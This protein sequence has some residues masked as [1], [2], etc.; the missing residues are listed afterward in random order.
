MRTRLLDSKGINPPL[1]QGRND[2]E[3]VLSASGKS[4][5]LVSSERLAR[6]LIGAVTERCLREAP[7][8]EIRAAYTRT[9]PPDAPNATATEFHRA[10]MT[11]HRRLDESRATQPGPE[12]RFLTLPIV[13]RC[14]TSP[15]PAATFDDTDVEPGP[16]SRIA[17]AKR[18]SVKDARARLKTMLGG[19][20]TAGRYELPESSGVLES[21]LGDN[22]VGVIHADGNGL[23]Q[24]FL[25]FDRIL[26]RMPASG[27]IASA[28]SYVDTLRRFSLALDACTVSAFRQALVDCDRALGLDR[29]PRSGD[30]P[31]SGAAYSPP[32]PIVPLILGGDDLTVL[33]DG[34]IALL[35]ASSFL[36]AFERETAGDSHLGGIVRQVAEAARPVRLVRSMPGLSSCAGIAVVKRHHPFH[37]AYDMAEDLLKSAK[38]V[39]RI[40][41]KDQAAVPCSALDFHINYA[42]SAD[43]IGAARAT[44]IVDGGDTRLTARPYVVTGRQWLE[45]ADPPGRAWAER[46]DW[47]DLLVRHSDL[48]R[49][50]KNSHLDSASGDGGDTIDQDTS[51]MM[52]RR[53]LHAAREALFL[54]HDRADGCLA[55]LPKNYREL[56]VKTASGRAGSLF[57]DDPD[58]AE[59]PRRATGLI[60]VMDLDEQKFEP[61][62]SPS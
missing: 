48:R 40:V 51:S 41:R 25:G 59:R 43:R 6:R 23:G 32:L 39:K 33:C 56:M 44:W 53:A 30:D 47:S 8:L 24:M 52:A 14:D 38:A 4:M 16:R 45:D 31:V 37:H 26:S 1:T 7:G 54:G 46:R 2:I 10:V 49:S 28:R 3:V 29:A 5:I 13:A 62:E 17:R 12:H 34:R 55:T 58:P 36:R 57:F 15:M 42:T 20:G 27:T 22:W 19:G 18:V 60:D 50:L 21:L 35:L 11:V 9:V 61:D